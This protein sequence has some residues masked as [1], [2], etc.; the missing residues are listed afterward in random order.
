MNI[1]NTKI[2]VA[3]DFHGQLDSLNL[4]FDEAGEPC[5]N[6]PYV[7]LGDYADRGKYG[8]ELVSLLLAYKFLFPLQIILLRGM[9]ELKPINQIYGL[10]DECTTKYP[11]THHWDKINQVFEC[12]PLAAEI[13]SR[14]FCCV[15]GLTPNLDSVEKIKGLSDSAH[16]PSQQGNYS[17]TKKLMA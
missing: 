14:I 4:L 9:H 17:V 16:N 12:L 6:N 7:F 5:P 8:I 13:N 2:V 15:G 11:N 3:G 1:P 10:K